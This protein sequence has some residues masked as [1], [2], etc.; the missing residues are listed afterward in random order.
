MANGQNLS[1]SLDDV[2]DFSL[3]AVAVIFTTCGFVCLP[4]IFDDLNKNSIFFLLTPMWMSLARTTC[5][6]LVIS[7][8]LNML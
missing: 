6:P 2:S 5:V 4:C 7:P 3:D 1:L 8:T